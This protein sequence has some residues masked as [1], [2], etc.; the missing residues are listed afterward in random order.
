MWTFP[1]RLFSLL[2]AQKGG[3]NGLFMKSVD[4][5]KLE[6]AIETRWTSQVVLVGKNAPANARDIRD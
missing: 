1:G 4:D 2:M 5:T 3:E 6:D